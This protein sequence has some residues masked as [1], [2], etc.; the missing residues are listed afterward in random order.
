MS[1]ITETRVQYKKPDICGFDKIKQTIILIEVSI[2]SQNSLQEVEIEKFHEYDMTYWQMNCQY[3]MMQVK[4]IP[5][6]LKWD[7]VVSK[8][9]TYYMDKITIEKTTKVT[10][11][12]LLKRTLEIIDNRECCLEIL[13]TAG[14]EQF[15]SVY[16]MYMRKGDGF[17]LVY[18]L[19]E[20]QTFEWAQSL[21]SRIQQYHSPKTMPV[22]IVGNKCDLKSSWKI[23]DTLNVPVF[24]TSAK[25]AQNVDR[26]DLAC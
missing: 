19:A 4:T 25:T 14:T 17:L 23:P 11:N 12:F 13:D 6:G 15:Y 7:G 2:T 18:S 9:F 16:E 8:C 10:S 24:E 5:V 1:I 3:F 21:Y 20:P 22:V 26:V